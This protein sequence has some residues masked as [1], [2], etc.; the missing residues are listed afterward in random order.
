MQ[1]RRFL[2]QAVAATGAGLAAV[3]MPAVA[4]G[5]PSVRWRMSTGWPK[6]LDAIY[7]SAEE[8]CRRVSELTQG[9]FEIRAF[10]G[11]EIVPYCARLKK[12]AV[13]SSDA[14]PCVRTRPSR[15]G[16]CSSNC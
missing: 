3:G 14:V 13:S 15:P 9:K 6:S 4:Q 12:K 16:C 10:P 8:L 1:R 2:T 5:T 11:G 7:G